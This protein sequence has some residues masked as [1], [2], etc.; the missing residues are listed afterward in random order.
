MYFSL[1]IILIHAAVLAATA[2]LASPSHAAGQIDASTLV[3]T[4]HGTFSGVDYIRYEA[5]FRRID[6]Q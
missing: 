5:M 4:P 3:S 1:R 2:A 6:S